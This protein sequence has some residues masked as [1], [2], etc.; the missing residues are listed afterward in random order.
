MEKRGE[1]PQRRGRKSHLRVRKLAKE[2]PKEKDIN[3]GFD[4]GDY[5]WSLRSRCM[6]GESTDGSANGSIIGHPCILNYQNK[7]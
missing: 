3:G 2:F 7:E 6:V 5:E 4:K 1:D